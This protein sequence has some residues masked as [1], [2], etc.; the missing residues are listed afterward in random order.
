MQ[1][2]EFLA[3]VRDD[4]LVAAIKAAEG[5]TSGEI[6]VFIS[7][8]EIADAVIAAQ[9]AFTKLGMTQTCER[10]GVLIFVAPRTQRFAVVGDEGIHRYCG[11]DFWRLLATEMSGHFKEGRFTEGLVLGITKAGALLATH[12][13]HRRDDQNELPDRVERD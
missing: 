4:E 3:Q 11:P 2:R 1:T 13:P 5:R 6:R 9:V 7:E 8:K 12:F 10:N